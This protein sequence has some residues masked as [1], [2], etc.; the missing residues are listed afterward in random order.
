VYEVLLGQVQAGAGGVYEVHQDGV[1]GG[2]YAGVVG[3]LEVEPDV[4]GGCVSMP[5]VGLEEGGVVA[6]GVVLVVGVVELVVDVLEVVSGVNELGLLTDT[7]IDGMR[8]QDEVCIG[9]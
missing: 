8:P 3:G 1:V 9:W 2:L 4:P 7:L 5:L 6:G